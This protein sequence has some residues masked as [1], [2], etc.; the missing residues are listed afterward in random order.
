[1]YAVPGE[2][3]HA[4]LQIK[5]DT[6]YFSL[7]EKPEFNAAILPVDLH[8]FCFAADPGKHPMFRFDT[9]SSGNVVSLE[10]LEFKFKK[11]KIEWR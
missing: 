8:R 6:L 4:E 3:A 9:D 11:N 7:K 5:N 1:M 2:Y 10:F